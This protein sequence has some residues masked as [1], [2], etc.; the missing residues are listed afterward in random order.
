[1]IAKVKEKLLDPA[2]AMINSDLV[3]WDTEFNKRTPHQIR[4]ATDWL[5]YTNLLLIR[6]QS[7]LDSTIYTY[8]RAYRTFRLIKEFDPW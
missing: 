2:N 8:W 1:M 6:T 7:K 3:L 4:M 5:N